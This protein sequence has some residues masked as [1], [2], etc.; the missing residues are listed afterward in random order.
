MITHIDTRP[1][2]K[3]RLNLGLTIMSDESGLNLGTA[4]YS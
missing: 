2:I 1:D 3:V 4:K